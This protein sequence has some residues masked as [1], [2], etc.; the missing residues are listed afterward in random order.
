M[1]ICDL[2]FFFFYSYTHSSV[3]SSV[4]WV[5]REVG[6]LHNLPVVLTTDS[7]TE[8]EKKM[9]SGANR[10]GANKRLMSASANFV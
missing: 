4:S 3:D 5:K 9:L 8:S 6:T 1:T 7:F 2:F 10:T